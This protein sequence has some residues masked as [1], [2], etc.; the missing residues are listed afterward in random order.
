MLA[1]SSVLGAEQLDMLSKIN[2]ED[3]R[4][5]AM[6]FYL[7]AGS[8]IA[9]R[10]SWTAEQIKTYEKS[11]QHKAALAELEKVVAHFS[12]E[13]PEYVLHV[14]T[15]IRS[16]EEQTTLWHTVSS[17]GDA[18]TALREAAL[19]TLKSFP[20]DP[21]EAAVKR[22]RSFLNAW[23]AP[24]WTTVMAP[25]MSL[26]GRGRAYDFQIRDK[27][28]GMIADNNASSVATVWDR[29]GWRDKLSHAVHAASSKFKGPLLKPNEP[30]HYEYEPGP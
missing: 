30:W 25:G 13:N 5:L 22:F 19:A 16:L 20:K 12:V 18:A 23:R 27:K 11:A 3:R 7:R 26:H 6:T 1:A 29:Q 15:R 9:T 4:H 10:W 8:S 14:N 28:G 24:R 21:D 2:D 17:V